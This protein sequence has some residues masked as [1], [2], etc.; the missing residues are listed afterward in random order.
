MRKRGIRGWILAM[1]ILCLD[2]WTK[3][4]ALT[5]KPMGY[6]VIPHCFNFTL[7]TNRGSLWG[8]GSAYT[9]CLSVFGVL[10]LFILISLYRKPP[11]NHYPYI[12]GSL[13]GGI[14][15]NTY[16]RCVHGYVV[17]FFDFYIGNRHWPCFNI[18]DIAISVTCIIL[19]FLSR[20]PKTV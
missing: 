19:L 9:H 5:Y 6:T 1:A 10:A 2:Q 7:V 11:Y 16:D 15:G 8:I 20:K 13:I 12:F 18:A 17:D 14:S 3:A 4:L